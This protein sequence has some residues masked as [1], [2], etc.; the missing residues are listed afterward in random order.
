MLLAAF[1]TSTE[2]AFA[3]IEVSVEEVK[4][5]EEVVP[6][7]KISIDTW[8]SMNAIETN[9]EHK[10]ENNAIA[11][12]DAVEE[13]KQSK[14]VV[15]NEVLEPITTPKKTK[16]A[17]SRV[18]TS[19][20]FSMK[21][22]ANDIGYPTVERPFVFFHI[23]KCFGS[24]LRTVFRKA[25]ESLGKR[26]LLPCYDSTHCATT[27]N[28]L[29][30][31]GG[32]PEIEQKAACAEIFAGHFTTKLLPI[33]ADNSN[34]EVNRQCD[35]KWASLVVDSPTTPFFDCL[36][37][38]RNPISRFVSHY[39]HFIEKDHPIYKGKKL[40]NLSLE[41]LTAI[42]HD[43]ANNTM[44]DYLSKHLP[45]IEPDRQVSSFTWDEKIKEAKFFLEQCVIIVNEDWETS[46]HLAESAV[47]WLKGHLT[48]AK[49]L[50][51]GK[52]R[53]EHETIEDFAPDIASS[54]KEMLNGDIAVYNHALDVY[55]EQLHNFRIEP[56]NKSLNKVRVSSL[57]EDLPFVKA[58]TYFGRGNPLNFWDQRFESYIDADF[59]TL[60]E[61]GFNTLI[62]LVPWAGVQVTVV[63]P[64]YKSFI[65]ERIEFVMRKAVEH[66]LLTIFR[67]SYPHSF[68][69]T[70]VPVSTARC[71]LIMGADT[72]N[73]I[74]DGWLDYMSVMNSIFLKEEYEN[75]YLYSF[76][77]WEDFMCLID[78]GRFLADPKENNERVAAAKE[79]GFNKFLMEHYTSDELTD[80]YEGV[81]PGEYYIPIWGTVTEK[82]YV[83]YIRFID[84]KWWELVELGRSVHP[85]LS[86][87][88]R[89][90]IERGVVPYDLHFDDK[91][92]PKLGYWSGYMGAAKRG[93]YHAKKAL[94]SLETV[95]VHSTGNGQSPLIVGQFNFQDN[96]AH[97]KTRNFFVAECQEFLEQS[98]ALLKK[99]SK[100]YGLWAY[101]NYRESEIFNG[102]FMLSLEGWSSQKIGQSSIEID[103]DGFLQLSGISDD[104]SVRIEQG[105]KQRNEKECD[106]QNANMEVCFKYR[107]KGFGAGLHIVWD[108]KKVD[109]SIE[110]SDHWK[111]KCLR[112]Q[113]MDIEKHYTIGFLVEG[114]TSVNIDNV[115]MFCHT[116]GL[117]IRNVNNTFDPRCGEG[118]V[119]LNELL[120]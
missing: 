111:E 57:R 93:H 2:N 45:Y 70:N 20:L 54:L 27:E 99:Y 83:A 19:A 49:A 101:R 95:L 13:V 59:I 40:K 91:G 68:D 106:D 9:S 47:P 96:T 84:I 41:D 46:T 39:Y 24:T 73:G 92:P 1:E 31:G 69:P 98:S 76:T 77:S 64:T 100:G 107:M 110:F 102:S 81:E 28:D 51:V 117:F 17:D 33:L 58:V 36:I 66:G 4:Q 82:K 18:V 74:K 88:V 42:V 112:V 87:E 43:S 114:Q 60:R 72:S 90:D 67:V 5:S 78:L 97:Q 15:A 25:S 30:G 108:G 89:V 53:S 118:I 119:K 94:Q 29:L 38:V 63:P 23:P 71:R 113:S 32:N 12:I 103:E 86:M 7:E 16:V 8:I 52:R 44:V 50:N 10:E 34:N 14:E 6:D 61:E 85:N 48:T 35:R 80:M 21:T 75:S 109:A 104:S 62:L 26:I 37:A 65:L 56:S 11:P 115:E 3:P 55:Q 116:Q 120:G 105:I 79:I 22:L